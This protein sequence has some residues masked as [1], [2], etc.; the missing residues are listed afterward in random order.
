[1]E[2]MSP[3]LTSCCPLWIR[4]EHLRSVGSLQ[5]VEVV[6]YKLNAFVLAFCYNSLLVS[7]QVETLSLEE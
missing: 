5:P 2:P 3:A 1:M 7:Q 4:I 6:I